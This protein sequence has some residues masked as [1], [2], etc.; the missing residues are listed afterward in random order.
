MWELDYDGAL[1]LR[2]PKESTDTL[3]SSSFYKLSLRRYVREIL[4]DFVR[5]KPALTYLDYKK[6]ITLCQEE[7]DKRKI[8]LVVCEPLREYIESRELHIEIRSRLGV[9]LKAHD[10]KFQERFERY[11]SVVDEEMTR[12]LR[13]RQMC[14]HQLSYQTEDG[15]WSLGEAVYKRLKEKEQIMLDA[16]D[17][18]VLEAMPTSDED[19]EIIFSKL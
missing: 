4:F 17:N 6:V 5:F 10:P 9:E 12:K 3:Q 18:H 16:I 15:S 7:T 8:S 1:L 19:L 11:R 2:I 14:Y 13:D